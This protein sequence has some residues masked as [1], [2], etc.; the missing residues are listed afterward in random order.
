MKMQIEDKI[1]KYGLDTCAMLV[2]FNA[3]Q[4]TARKLD[5][6]T[7]EEVVSSKHA[8]NK[9]AARVNKHLLAG[10]N[11]LD[12]ISAHVNAVRN[13]VYAHTL[14]WSDS[15]L[16]LLPSTVYFTFLTKMEE[17]EEEFNKL[18][19]TF[20]LVYPTLITAQA[21]ALGDMFRRDDFPSPAE[22]KHK[23]DFRMNIMNVPASGDFR[24]DVGNDAQK[25]LKE[26]LAEANNARLEA[27][28]QG[29]RDALKEQLDRMS[30][31]L[32]EVES[33]SDDK[34]KRPK[35]YD[36]LLENAHDLCARIDV[37]N[38]T[39]D[40]DLDSA[41]LALKRVVAGLDIV[42]LRKD[43]TA[44]KE[45]KASVDEIRDRFSW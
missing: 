36:S 6:T 22:L 37:L 14:P 21:M 45:I 34:R 29:L 40:A 42:D 9:G 18:V 7:T 11:E 32:R 8:A 19:E 38:I 26:K 17:F 12:V 3:S 2:E 1:A 39:K 44:R 10:R 20:L 41:A 33:S 25:Y 16:R 31:Q 28:T 23:F 4:W 30:T 13:Y 43:S 24:V 5:K 27:A 15:G 35:L